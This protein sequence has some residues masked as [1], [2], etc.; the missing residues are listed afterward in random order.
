MA[1]ANSTAGLHM[2]PEPTEL[3]TTPPAH[4]AH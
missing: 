2:V 3:K 1:S 4:D